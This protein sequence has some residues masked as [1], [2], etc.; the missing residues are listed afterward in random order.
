MVSMKFP[1]CSNDSWVPVSSQATPRPSL[2]RN[3]APCARYQLLRSV[4]SSSPR[5]EGRNR[6]RQIAHLMVVEVETNHR[7]IGFRVP[8]LFSQIDHTPIGIGLHHAVTLRVAN[9][10]P[11]HGSPL[12]PLGRG[13]QLPNQA[14]AVKDIVAQDQATRVRGDECPADDEGLCQSAGFRLFRI[15]QADP[16]AAAVPQQVPKT[17]RIAGR[18]NDQNLADPRQHEYGEGIVDHGLVVDRQQLS[19]DGAGQGI[20][21]PPASTMPFLFMGETRDARPG[22]CRP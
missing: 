11:E 10:I 13:P 8:R 4:I 6:G 17:S 15:V 19:A 2:S 20:K 3:S 21:V 5:A 1:A 9:P 14:L 18:G 16:P 12:F 22:S 7:V